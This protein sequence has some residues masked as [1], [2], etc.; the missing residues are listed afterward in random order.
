[1]ASGSLGGLSA[2]APL[3]G[4]TADMSSESSPTPAPATQVS[5]SVGSS[6]QSSSSPSLGDVATQAVVATASAGIPGLSL[7]RNLDVSR[8]VSVVL[9]LLLIGGGIIM[10]R[11]VGEIAGGFTRAAVKGGKEAVLAA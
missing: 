1:M 11:P 10:F 7:V 5:S 6:S 8:A 9:G 2:L 3:T 4:L